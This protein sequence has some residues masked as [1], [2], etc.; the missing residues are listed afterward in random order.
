MERRGHHFCRI[1]AD[2]GCND[3]WDVH[4]VLFDSWTLEEAGDA[5]DELLR[6]VGTLGLERVDAPPGAATGEVWVRTDPRIDNE[7]ERWS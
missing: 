3:R 4:Y 6:C 2:S 1:W 7:L 5:R